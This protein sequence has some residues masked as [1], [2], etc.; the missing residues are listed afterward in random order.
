MEELKI[1]G[2]KDKQTYLIWTEPQLIR[3]RNEEERMQEERNARKTNNHGKGLKQGK[4]Q[5]FSRLEEI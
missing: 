4:C 2:D 3:K 1:V 5:T